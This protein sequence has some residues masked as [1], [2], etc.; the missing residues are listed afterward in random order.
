MAASEDEFCLADVK[1]QPQFQLRKV[2]SGA[3]AK[4]CVR[5]ARG[6]VMRVRA[7]RGPWALGL[8]VGR[9]DDHQT[10]STPAPRNCGPSRPCGVGVMILMG[11]R[12]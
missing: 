6:A 10:S 1:R 9:G 4:A 12:S 2:R 8:G 11:L 7:A 5:A 3:S